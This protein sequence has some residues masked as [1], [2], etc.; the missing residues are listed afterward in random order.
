MEKALGILLLRE[1]LRDLICLA[2]L[3]AF[4]WKCIGQ[5]FIGTSFKII[6]LF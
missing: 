4:G 2:K 5:T 3:E 6:I 1:A